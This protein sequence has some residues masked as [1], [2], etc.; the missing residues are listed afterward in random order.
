[1]GVEI[2]EEPGLLVARIRG[3]MT[4]T[5]QGTLVG[6]LDA[7]VQRTGRTKILVIVDPDFAG[8][9]GGEEWSHAGQFEGD[10]QIEKAALVC[11]PRWN[12]QM[13]AFIGKPFR[14]MPIEFF[15]SADAAREWLRR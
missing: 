15:S 12:D 10:E 4:V 5:D 13:F 9:T 14:H 7:L 3:K 1:M 11:D 6:A 2:H 8:W